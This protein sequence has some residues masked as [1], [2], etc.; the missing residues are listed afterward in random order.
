MLISHRYQF[1][2]VKTRKTA[3][4]S[5]E[6]SLSRYCGDTDVITPISLPDEPWRGQFGVCPQHYL[7]GHQADATGGHVPEWRRQAVR[8]MSKVELRRAHWVPYRMR[9]QLR[10]W[11]PRREI[12]GMGY[13]NHMTA[14]EIVEQVG[15]DIWQR[16]FKFC[17]ERNPLDKTISHYYYS[18]PSESFDAYLE[19]GDFCSDFDSYTLNG[20]LAVDFIGRFEHLSEDLNIVAQQLG[21]PFDG[22]LP[23]SKSGSRGKTIMASGLNPHQ[24]AIICQGF[25]RELAFLD[26]ALR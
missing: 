19:R 15:A 7:P 26:Y 10:N 18:A 3:G 23:R 13:Y 1:I 12:E 22:W 25:A 24:K 9:R 14:A 20:D 11:Q 4:T 16:Y 8:W 17:F 2:F 21:I 5:I 6:A